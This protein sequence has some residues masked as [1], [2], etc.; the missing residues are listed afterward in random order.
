MQGAMCALPLP[1]FP[2]GVMRGRFH[3]ADGALYACGMFAWAGNQTLPGG[4]YRIRPTGKPAFAPLE[5]HAR[6]AGLSITFSDPLNAD[7]VRADNFEFRVWGLKRTENYGSPHVDEHELEVRSARLEG[8]GRTVVLDI[9]E[10]KPTW[11]Y[12]VVASLKG[13][14]GEPVERTIHG[15]I[16]EIR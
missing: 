13:A 16:H 15:T 1:T 4:L 11:C 8:D 5:V 10:L 7:S 6:K 12:S 14:R 2:T 9:P 3:P